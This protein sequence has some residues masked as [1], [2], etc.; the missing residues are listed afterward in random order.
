[1]TIPLPLA[2]VCLALPSKTQYNQTYGS[3]ARLGHIYF[4]ELVNLNL[5]LFISNKSVSFNSK[6]RMN[7]YE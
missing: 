7:K 5:G 3:N 6:I 2:S 1:M 4:T